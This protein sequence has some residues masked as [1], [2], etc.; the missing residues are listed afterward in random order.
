MVGKLGEWQI[1]EGINSCL[2]P[3][4]LAS[5]DTAAIFRPLKSCHRQKTI[6]VS[7]GQHSWDLLVE[8]IVEI[9]QQWHWCF[10]S[11]LHVC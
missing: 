10:N 4:T 1:D 6:S 3:D 2:A 5:G 11:G 9:N 8:T 7:S